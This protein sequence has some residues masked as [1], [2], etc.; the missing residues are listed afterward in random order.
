M[1]LKKLIFILKHSPIT[2]DYSGNQKLL[3]YSNKQK[4]LLLQTI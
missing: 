3:A 4:L 1:N 2:L